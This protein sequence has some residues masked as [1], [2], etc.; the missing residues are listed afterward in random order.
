[1]TQMPCDAY[2]AV[3]RAAYMGDT[4]FLLRTPVSVQL[5]NGIFV[6][7]EPCVTSCHAYE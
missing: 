5:E 7:Y 4:A 3:G 1:M 2:E 6:R